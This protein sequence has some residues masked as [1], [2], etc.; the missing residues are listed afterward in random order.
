MYQC[1]KCAGKLEV[2]INNGVHIDKCLNCGGLWFDKKELLTLLTGDINF[3]VDGIRD[4][5]SKEYDKTTGMCPLCNVKLDHIDSKTEKDIHI[6]I[7]PECKGVWLDKGE[8]TALSLQ[9]KKDQLIQLL[10]N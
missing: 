5:T 9:K 6:D 1:P 8:L 7:C 4:E 10:K 3:M 2:V